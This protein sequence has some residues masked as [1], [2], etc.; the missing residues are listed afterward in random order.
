MSLSVLVGM[1]IIDFIVTAA[2]IGDRTRSLNVKLH[3]QLI[4][5][6]DTALRML[7]S[8]RGSAEQHKCFRTRVHAEM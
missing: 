2:G 8:T 1:H 5:Y 7:Q 4:V 6:Q 3:V